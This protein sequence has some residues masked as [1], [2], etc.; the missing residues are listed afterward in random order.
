MRRTASPRSRLRARAAR[1]VV[2]AAAAV[3]GAALAGAL[4]LG[5][6]VGGRAASPC[7]RLRL[8]EAPTAASMR[9][10]LRLEREGTECCRSAALPALGEREA[11]AAA[12]TVAPA[13]WVRLGTWAVASVR[14]TRA[15]AGHR[16]GRGRAP[17]PPPDTSTTVL[18]C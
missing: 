11:N 1:R 16:F 13:A 3:V 14:D 15:T 4:A 5:A 8:A 6:L 17:R 10:P 18:R 9:A 12:P 7:M 2:R